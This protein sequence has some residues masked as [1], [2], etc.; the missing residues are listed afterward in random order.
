[1]RCSVDGQEFRNS[2][3][4]NLENKAYKYSGIYNTFF[5]FSETNS[6]QDIAH[7]RSPEYFSHEKAFTK[8]DHTADTK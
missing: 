2:S 8:G 7:R 1:M 5:T 4:G 3:K 6:I